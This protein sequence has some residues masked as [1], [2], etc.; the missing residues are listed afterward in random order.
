MSKLIGF[1]ADA[2]LSKG[3]IYNVKSS[4]ITGH[5]INKLV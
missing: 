4:R 2:I 5:G 3:D 1:N